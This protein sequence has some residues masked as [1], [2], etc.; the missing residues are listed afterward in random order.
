VVEEINTGNR[1][2]G[3]LNGR[4][5]K[6]LGEKFF[7][8][9]EKQYTQMQLKNHWDNLKILYNFLDIALDQYWTREESKFGD[10]RGK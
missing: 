7:A 10:Y 3:T 8:T 6:C 5:Y 4:G 2:L 9:T 1:P